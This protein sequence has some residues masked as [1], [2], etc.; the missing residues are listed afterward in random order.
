MAPQSQ[1]TVVATHCSPFPDCY[2]GAPRALALPLSARATWVPT[3]GLPLEGP[4]ERLAGVR[5]APSA[6]LGSQGRAGA[7]WRCERM[8]AS[9]VLL[10]PSA[11]A[12]SHP[13]PRLVCFLPFPLLPSA[14]VR[15][16]TPKPLH[17]GGSELS[18][19]AVLSGRGS[20]QAPGGLSPAPL[21]RLAIRSLQP[22]VPQPP[23]GSPPT[24]SP[25]SANCSACPQ[26]KRPPS[27]LAQR[28]ETQKMLASQK[29]HFTQVSR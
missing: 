20:A 14:L 21:K 19:L 26:A 4:Q 1:V 12:A 28:H 9:L 7:A 8:H 25:W 22:R 13:H 5:P 29:G 15:P 16:A 17:A 6:A 27:H 2:P 23:L 10:L 24:L 3:S 18:S 11:C